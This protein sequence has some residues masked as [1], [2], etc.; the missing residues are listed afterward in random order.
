MPDAPEPH[1]AVAKHE[2][3]VLVSCNG[4]AVRSLSVE[5]VEKMWPAK[6]KKGAAKGTLCKKHYKEFKKET[7]D[8]RDLERAG[9]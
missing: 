8:E 6:V 1:H 9:W 2:V 3:C 5:K 4:E 7:R